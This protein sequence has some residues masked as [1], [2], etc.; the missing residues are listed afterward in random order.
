MVASGTL[1]QEVEALRETV[2]ALR[3]D[4]ATRPQIT[5]TAIQPPSFLGQSVTL[6]ATALDGQGKPLYDAPVTFVATWGRL[7]VL[8]PNGVTQGQTITARTAVDGTARVT[9]F[10][11]LDE[12]L[13]DHQQSALQSTLRILDGKAE[14]PHKIEAQ[15][16]ELVRRYNWEANVE[17]REAIDIYFREF[18]GR[19]QETINQYDYLSAWLYFDS[20][21]LAYVSDGSTV[22]TTAVLSLQFKDWLSPLLET[23]LAA[24]QADSRLEEDMRA[25]KGYV[26]DSQ[27]LHSTLLAHVRDFVDHR[28]GLFGEYV[29]RRIAERTAQDF[30][31]RE[32][33]DLPLET[34]VALFPTLDV[35]AHTLVAAG[36]TVLAAIGQTR[37]D[38]QREIDTNISRL[39]PKNIGK[40]GDRLAGLE[41]AL[42]SKLDRNSLGNA[43]NEALVGFEDRVMGRVD[44]RVSEALSDVEEGLLG[45][46]DGRITEAFAGLEANLD[47]RFEGLTQQLDD[48][49]AGKLDVGARAEIEDSVR[50]SVDGQLK[51]TLTNFQ[52]TQDTRFSQLEAGLNS[53]VDATALPE[54]QRAVDARLSGMQ[55]VLN[56]RLGLVETALNSKLDAS[57]LEGIQDSLLERMDGRLAD[58]LTVLERDLDE[59][60]EGLT[61]DIDERLGRKLDTTVLQ[62]FEEALLGRVDGQVNESLT[63]LQQTMDTRIAGLESSVNTRL[64]VVERDLRGKADVTALAELQRSTDTQIG[65]LE[66]TFDSRLNKIEKD[67]DSKPDRRTLTDFE[68]TLTA[69]FTDFE[70]TFDTRLEGVVTAN[71]LKELET[72]FDK[73]LETR[74][75]EVVTDLRGSLDGGLRTKLNSATFTAFERSVTA[76]LDK[77]VESEDFATFQTSINDTLNSKVDVPTFNLFQTTVNNS[78]RTKVDSTTFTNF[79]SSVN[80]SLQGKLEATAFQQF[81]GTVDTQLKT[82]E[83]RSTQLNTTLNGVQTSLNDIRR[84]IGG[85]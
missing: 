69:R 43:L 57:A 84:K 20:T 73:T 85:T 28:R 17:L 80:N 4:V 54:F 1:V 25:A 56:T 71:D 49:F 32:L 78:L 8:T 29:G 39:D 7:R 36:S 81:A 76:A 19:L 66:T 50:E 41:R 12:N 22:R 45:R 21:V 2:E 24:E 23:F 26:Q 58:S 64:T 42:D 52:R 47:R 79:Q 77:K 60:F 59:R 44:G 48:R 38:L 68:N 67:L 65:G 35:A 62:G 31:S 18:R 6:L 27:I 14:S 16:R 13:Y 40:I 53:K 51:D 9:L 70:R 34:K 74:L 82:L 15:F 83:N 3:R 55:N 33:N 61:K 30:I 37:A 11:P 10:P 72:R 63:S 5:L 75:N 46:V